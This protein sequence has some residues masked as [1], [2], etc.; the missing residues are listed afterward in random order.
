VGFARELTERSTF[1]LLMERLHAALDD[2]KIAAL[3]ST[4][5]NMTEDQ[6]LRLAT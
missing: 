2:A 1:D 3:V 6:A 4:G 5:K